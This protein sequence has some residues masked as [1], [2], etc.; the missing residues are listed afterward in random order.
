MYN[1]IKSIFLKK[2]NLSQVTVKQSIAMNDSLLNKP[3]PNWEIQMD[4]ENDVNVIK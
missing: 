2:K 1:N 3:K 4:W